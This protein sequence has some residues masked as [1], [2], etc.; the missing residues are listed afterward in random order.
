MMI[1]N[2][3]DLEDQRD[4]TYEEASN[5]AKENGLIFLEASA[6]TCVV[7]ASSHCAAGR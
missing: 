2:K 4:V 1:G 7:L 3:K 5:F 6:K